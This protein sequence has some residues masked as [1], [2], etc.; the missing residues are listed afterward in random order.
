MSSEQ[1]KQR[2]AVVR[3]RGDVNL[4]ADIKKTFQLLRLYRKNYCIVVPNTPSISA[5]IFNLLNI[6]LLRDLKV[7]FMSYFIN[8]K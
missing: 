1:P 5:M 2:V 6:Y 3:I 7:I 8:Y 4:S